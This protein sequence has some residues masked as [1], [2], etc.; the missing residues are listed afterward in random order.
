MLVALKSAALD[1]GALELLGKLPGLLD[2]IGD[3]VRT[4]LPPSQYNDLAFLAEGIDGARVVSVVTRFPLVHPGQPGD[5]RGAVQIPD[6]EA[7]RAMAAL[8]F[9]APG[10]LPTPWPT[11]KPTA[12][13][14]SSP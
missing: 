10:T 2:A 14:G 9:P 5:P 11:P 12:T 6:G 7:I 4:D 1:G 3:A 8:L 13:P